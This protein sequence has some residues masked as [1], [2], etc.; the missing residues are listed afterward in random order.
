MVRTNSRRVCKPHPI[1]GY[2]AY[3]DLGP[4]E[5]LED[6]HRR[7]EQPFEAAYPA[8][9]AA[10]KGIVAVAEIQAGDVHSRLD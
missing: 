6:G 5:V 1:A 7:V 3:A 2:R 4:R 9:D 8:N 10:V